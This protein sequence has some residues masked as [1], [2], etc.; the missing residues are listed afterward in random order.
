MKPFIKDPDA[1]LDY[2]WDWSSWL[3]DDA[4]QTA[5][6]AAQAGLTLDHFTNS[7][8]TVT[9]WLKGGTEGIM[10]GVSCRIVTVAGRIDDRTINVL[11]RSK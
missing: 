3:E 7:A 8:T 11:I 2:E 4:I 1:N 10:Y 6:V 9:A 5:S